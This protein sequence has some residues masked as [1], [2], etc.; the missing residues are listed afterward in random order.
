MVGH[1]HGDCID[2]V[3]ALDFGETFVVG[4]VFFLQ[5]QEVVD[6]II[7]EVVQVVL[8]FVHVELD[9]GELVHR[10]LDV[11]FGNLADGLF[12][13]RKH[14]VA[15]DLLPEKRAV[16]VEGAFDAVDL[17]IP[18]FGILLQLLIDAFFEEDFLQGNLVPLLAQLV[19]L[20][21]Q[22]FAQQVEGVLGVD[23]QDVLD[24][25][26]DGLAVPYYAGIGG[27]GDFAVGEGVECVNGLVGG[28]TG[29]QVE[30]DFCLCRRI[31]VYLL[32]F[33]LAVVNGLGDGVGGFGDKIFGSGAVRNLVDYQSLVIDNADFGAVTDFAALC[34]VVVAAHVYGAA[35]RE[36]GVDLEI[37]A[38]QDMYGGVN[39]LVEVV[40]QDEGGHTHADTLH[41]LGKQQR[42]FDGQRDG[43]TVT[44]VVG[45]LPL[46]GFMVEDHLFRKRGEAR[47]DVTGSCRVVA[48]EN[49]TPV[50]LRVD[51]QVLLSHL[52][53][54][55][56]D[57]LVAVRVV[58]HGVTH[59]ISHLVEA[60]VLQLV[61]RVQDTALHGL[62]AVIHVRESTVEDD[63]GGVV[64]VPFAVHR[65]CE[66]HFVQARLVLC[67]CVRIFLRDNDFTRI[68][69]SF[70]GQFFVFE[71]FSHRFWFFKPRRY[72]FFNEEC[73]MMNEECL[74]LQVFLVDVEL[75][76]LNFGH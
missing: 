18:G 36:V 41:A 20:D 70:F 2:V 4:T 30:V 16:G 63:V 43:L 29:H 73:R 38:A 55:C 52:H 1:G 71:F 17:C 15:G 56:A 33:Q 8:H 12:A 62:E 3:E 65:L 11:E 50:T 34:A 64:Q 23:A 61:H 69:S 68:I 32:D 14:V 28:D 42:E 76:T 75:W 40:G 54:S 72:D 74:S 51:E 13:E 35:G 10:G 60:A 6:G 37:L 44:A 58:L 67:T 57:G 45:D 59:D 26:E 46:C 24:V 19:K 39:Q 66:N 7:D 27:V 49:V 48:G 5:L 9:F 47:L 22:L 25:G 21:F 31:V 53:E